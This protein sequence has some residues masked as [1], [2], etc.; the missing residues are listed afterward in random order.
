MPE[1]PSAP[2]SLSRRD[3]CLGAWYAAAVAALGG[4]T[5]C[6]SA[7]APVIPGGLAAT[8][9]GCTVTVA[10][11]PAS[12]L[13]SV[14][15][16]ALLQTALGDF[17]IPRTGAGTFGVLSAVCTHQGCTITGFNDS[18]FECPCHGSRF[19]TSGSVARGPATRSFESF[20]SAFDGSDPVFDA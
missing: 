14:G 6:A 7:A 15:S 2:K 8:V 10:I 18:E 11:T 1:S 3:L 16:V 12:P 13:A 5:G 20:A 9:N 17:L 19:T 4:S